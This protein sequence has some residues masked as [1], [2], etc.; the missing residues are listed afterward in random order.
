MTVV[1][2]GPAPAGRPAPSGRPAPARLGS[3][4]PPHKGRRPPHRA[5]GSG[6]RARA[7][8]PPPLPL[9]STDAGLVCASRPR[10][11]GRGG[12]PGVGSP[13]HPPR[14]A[15]PCA[16]ARGSP[17][18]GLL[19]CPTPSS[20]ALLPAAD[21]SGARRARHGGGARLRSRGR[22]EGGTPVRSGLGAA[23]TLRSAPLAPARPPRAPP[24]RSLRQPD[25]RCLSSS[26]VRR[27]RASPGPARR[28]AAAR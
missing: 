21:A 8:S 16:R 17:P 6:P 2:P 7:P 20:P 3:P 1:L 14:P 25:V 4:P 22:G 13:P 24:W 28:R 18:E 19:R 26:R 15:T 9:R 23:Y 11:A 5:Q 27:G 12:G 10:H